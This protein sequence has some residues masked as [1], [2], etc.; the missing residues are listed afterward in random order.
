MKKLLE[1]KMLFYIG[2]AILLFVA[3]IFV[4][5]SNFSERVSE[6]NMFHFFD[7]HMDD[8][9]FVSRVGRGE[10]NISYAELIVN[11]DSIEGVFENYRRATKET[12]IQYLPPDIRRRV[13][14]LSPDYDLDYFYVLLQS[15]RK[16]F[17]VEAVETREKHIVFMQEQ[18]G[19]VLVLLF[20]THTGIWWR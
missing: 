15:A 14:E 1:R 19:Y 18:G 12:D 17:I 4:I 2:V 20:C 3:I 8:R 11:A 16:G 7:I 9:V 10:H 5:T 13:E 6:S